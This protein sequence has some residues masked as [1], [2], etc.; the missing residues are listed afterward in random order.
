MI[1]RKAVINNFNDALKLIKNVGCSSFA[2]TLLA[3]KS[4]LNAVVVEGIDNRAA[5]IL[6][7]EAISV[8]ADA[9]I[10]ENISR[11]KQ[12]VSDLVLFAN[13]SQVERLIV[14]F[15]LQ[16]FGLKEVALKLEEIINKKKIFK[17]RQKSLDLS[18]PVVM[19]IVNM[20]PNSFSGD[21]LTDSDKACAQVIEFER[22][23]AQ[24]ID[25]GAESS[26]PGVK[27]IDA[28]TE[29]NRLIPTLKKI[30]K[31]VKIPI[32]VDTYKYET[33]KAA[34]LEGA[35]IVNDIF[36]LRKGKEKLAKL[37]ADTKAGV[38]LMHMKGI[39][40]NMQ[41]SPEYKNC[42]SEVY[43]FLAERKKYT[44]DFGIEKERIAVDPGH[45]FGKTVKHNL[46]LVKNMDVFST[47]G[48]VVGAVSRKRFVRTLAGEDK[49]AFIVANF[50][51]VLCG[52]DIIRVHDVKETIN[53]LK[54]IETF[55]GV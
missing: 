53:V 51:T 2:C 29:I 24:I 23:G 9:A 14:K 55:R 17:Y 26:R 18:N 50:L 45:G 6:K 47:L 49:T 35:D 15:R 4:L 11:F 22:L 43:E 27:L 21:G 44:M 39:P 31:N 16:P 38:I 40:K 41:E 7:Q 19:G 37:I 30:R 13:L 10:N 48:T 36:A 12:G 20:D 25:I 28:K 52:A 1:I 3:K 32:S 46:E 42:T 5:N 8:G 34:L 33:A 54:I